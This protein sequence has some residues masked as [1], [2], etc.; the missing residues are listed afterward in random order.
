MYE[1]DY[2][3]K[4]IYSDTGSK[5]DEKGRFDWKAVEYYT[6]NDRVPYGH[7]EKSVMML[8][9]F[10]PLVNVWNALPSILIITGTLF[11]R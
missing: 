1:I 11:V 9:E 5:K 4:K 6:V 8:E 2:K 3:N 7:G 10:K